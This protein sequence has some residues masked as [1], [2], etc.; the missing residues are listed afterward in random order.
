[1]WLAEVRQ[2]CKWY[3]KPHQ[4]AP[5]PG[6][7]AALDTKYGQQGVLSA[8][9]HAVNGQRLP[10][11]PQQQACTR[12]CGNRIHLCL[13]CSTALCACVLVALQ[14]FF[15][16]AVS[17]QMV[18][19]TLDPMHVQV[20]GQLRQLRTP[21]TEGV[22]HHVSMRRIYN[23]RKPKTNIQ[24]LQQNVLL[25]HRHLMQFMRRH[26]RDVAA[27]VRAAYIETLSR[28]LSGHFKAYLTALEPLLV[29][30]HTSPSVVSIETPSRVLSGHVKAYP[31]A[32]K[33][34]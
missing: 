28:V 34:R 24:I 13:S 10:S 20:L 6:H 14:V 19:Y 8:A 30:C 17:P 2:V 31:T 29:S 18:S 26:G 23:L 15:M 25:K 12:W 16:K 21:A 5:P 1:M 22:T 9:V 3:C 33:P 11:W 27:E 7:G 32:C 4:I